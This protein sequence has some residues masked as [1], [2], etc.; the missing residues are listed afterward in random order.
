MLAPAQTDVC[1]RKME[2]ALKVHHRFLVRV[3]SSSHLLVVGTMEVEVHEGC[4][5]IHVSKG[6]ASI[7]TETYLVAVVH[8]LAWHS[9]LD[10]GRK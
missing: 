6:C 3:R 10:V 5:L 2:E 8:S 7:D 4:R 9:R 1:S